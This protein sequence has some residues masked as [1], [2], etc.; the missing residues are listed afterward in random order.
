MA[1][2]IGVAGSDVSSVF[3]PQSCSYVLIVAMVNVG[4]PRP[5]V[6]KTLD[7]RRAK[8]ERDATTV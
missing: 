5:D 7:T 6:W 2:L 8:L 3:K 1:W 4:V